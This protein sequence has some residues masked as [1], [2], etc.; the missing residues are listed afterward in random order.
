MWNYLENHTIAIGF[1]NGHTQNNGDFLINI[2]K[3]DLATQPGILRQPKLLQS[4]VCV[5]SWL[6]EIM[7][8]LENMIQWPF[9]VAQL[10]GSPHYTH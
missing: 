6:L 9:K 8:Y 2:L 1:I 10:F 5:F 7:I 4:I 3:A